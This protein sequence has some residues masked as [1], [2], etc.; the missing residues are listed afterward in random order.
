MKKDKYVLHLLPEN[1][2]KAFVTIETFTDSLVKYDISETKY[3]KL[4]KQLFKLY[5]DLNEALQ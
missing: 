3:K 4:R 5:D 1:V 2:H